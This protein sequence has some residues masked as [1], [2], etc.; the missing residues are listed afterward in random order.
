[1]T[2]M[3]IKMSPG[4]AI[5][6]LWIAFAV[7]WAVAALWAARAEK[8]AGLSVEAPY[9]ITM[10]AGAA[11]L[12]VPA[13]R[14]QGWMRLWQV[15][16]AEAWACVGLMAA[17]L[18]LAWWARLHLGRLWSG[19]ITKKAEH[20]IVETGPYAIVR[21]P[22]YTGLVVAIL[23]TM[24]AK[25]TLPGIAGAALITTGIYMKARLEERFL[26]AEL[27]ADAYDAYSRRVPMLIPFT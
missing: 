13:H 19:K 27:G 3:N 15:N 1:M 9:R 22:I 6:D 17:G 20:R 25:G 14:Y 10:L 11:L 7:T 5:M 8:S 12:A 23:A 16:A 2:W 4:I 26:R 18:A 24:L 21:H